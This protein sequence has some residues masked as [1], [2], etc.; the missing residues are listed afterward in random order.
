[1]CSFWA[2]VLCG[3]KYYQSAWLDCSG[4]I[5]KIH[6]RKIRRDQ[7]ASM[8]MRMT[9]SWK[10]TVR[11]GQMTTPGPRGPRW[12]AMLKE[13]MARRTCFREQYYTGTRGITESGRDCRPMPAETICTI[14]SVYQP[15][16][17]I[18]QFVWALVFCGTRYYQSAWL[19]Y[20]GTIQKIH[21]RKIR[22][23]QGST[24]IMNLDRFH[25]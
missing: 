23:L 15:Y 9:D 4:T 6:M 7:G 13:H 22:W 25:D 12:R 10:D 21:M 20:S 17:W 18:D 3:S 16:L 14:W 11:Q 5:Q 8:M 1:M 24:V 19:E 2:R